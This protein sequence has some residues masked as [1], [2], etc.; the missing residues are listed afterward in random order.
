MEK[1]DDPFFKST[2]PINYVKKENVFPVINT[3][4]MPLYEEH[5]LV[6]WAY[7][8][9]KNILTYFF[10][11]T[12]RVKDIK[13]DI[14]PCTPATLHAF[15]LKD[16]PVTFS[17]KDEGP[18]S[19]ASWDGVLGH[20]WDKVANGTAVVMS[21]KFKEDKTCTLN[22]NTNIF[23]HATLV[24]NVNFKTMENYRMHVKEYC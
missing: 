19:T 6:Y 20:E 2:V 4:S 12:N 14:A 22:F 13:R 17:V 11:D 8:N 9:L 15:G 24:S 21:L 18:F 7:S 1:H 5:S 16:G 3:P 23:V 10:S